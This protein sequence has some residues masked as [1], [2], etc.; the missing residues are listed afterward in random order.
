MMPWVFAGLS[1]LTGTSLDSQEER[2]VAVFRDFAEKIRFRS[3][4]ATFETS[5]KSQ[6]DYEREYNGSLAMDFVRNQAC[7]EVSE[8][9]RG[10]HILT[11]R[12]SWV[13][14][15]GKEEDALARLAQLTGV[16]SGRIP[17]D[18]VRTKLPGEH[19]FLQGMMPVGFLIK[20]RKIGRVLA[21]D[22]GRFRITVPADKTAAENAKAKNYA[23]DILPEAP[24]PI[25]DVWVFVPDA[26]T[27]DPRM[28][29]PEWKLDCQGGYLWAF[30]HWH[31]QEYRE[32]EGIPFPVRWTYEAPI[33]NPSLRTELT[34]KEVKLD[35]DPPGG[36]DF[37]WKPGTRVYDQFRMTVW[38]VGG[39]TLGKDA[40]CEG[41]LERILEGAGC[42]AL[43]DVPGDIWKPYP[44]NCAA[45]AL[46]F[47]GRW[48]GRPVRLEGILRALGWNGKG[49]L[50]EVD[51][52][53]LCDAAK[54]LGLST[55]PVKGGRDLLTGPREA[56]FLAHCL[57]RDGRGHFAA[58]LGYEGGAQSLRVLDP[59]FL[60]LDPPLS[61]FECDWTGAG[62]LFSEKD[63]IRCREASAKRR[64]Q[65]LLLTG[66]CALAA[67]LLAYG[68]GA[69]VRRVRHRSVSRDAREPEVRS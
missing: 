61:V 18:F 23:Y 6:V 29:R 28:V 41:V 69:A 27:H 66:V 13:E 17:G 22:G 39:E 62:V 36:Y 24:H 52:L 9:E 3:L 50:G 64:V 19:P 53:T 68:V 14:G 30:G 1:A 63:L 12:S 8:S 33:M 60:P 31:I 55:Y 43:E 40:T 45:N 5:V 38:Q 59:P 25:S 47:I 65:W 16:L 48:L 51:L 57:R 35:N 11:R 26:A 46:Y 44:S 37:E 4:L 2:A 7:M 67:G 21:L 32:V 20:E 54:A 34:L 58:V 49:E 56:P 15:I 42:A 10:V